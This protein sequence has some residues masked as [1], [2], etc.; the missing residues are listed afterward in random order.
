MFEWVKL[1]VTII[2][3]ILMVIVFF[4]KKNV[5]N[6]LIILLIL[7]SIIIFSLRFFIGNEPLV[8]SILSVVYFVII[9]IFAVLILK[10]LKLNDE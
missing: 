4:K 10:A 5:L 9:T 2:F 8:D 6:W 3:I 7:H 1:G